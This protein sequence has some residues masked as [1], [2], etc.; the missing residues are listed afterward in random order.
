MRRTVALGLAVLLLA[1]CE[2]RQ[3]AVEQ[4]LPAARVTKARADAQQLAN[5]VRLY[6]ATYGTLPSDLLALTRPGPGG[7]P[8]LASIPAPPPGWGMYAYAA[9]QSGRFSIFTM[10]DG[11][12]VSAP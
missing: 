7:G 3:K 6:Q 1:G 9:E 11:V 10:G 8:I 2:A 12:T 5:A 4:D